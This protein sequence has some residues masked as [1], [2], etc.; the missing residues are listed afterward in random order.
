MGKLEE[1]SRL[2]AGNVQDSLGIGRPARPVEVPASASAPSAPA[3]WQGVT[4]SKNAVEIPK[5]DPLVAA[6]EKEIARLGA[7][8]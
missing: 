6:K 2:T 7:S 3:R 1:L 5:F 4:K 8:K